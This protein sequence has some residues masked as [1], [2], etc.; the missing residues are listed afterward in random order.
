MLIAGLA[1][2]AYGFKADRLGRFVFELA[3]NFASHLSDALSHYFLYIY[4]FSSFSPLG[5]RNLEEIL[6]LLSYRACSRLVEF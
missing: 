5:K 2:A 1:C 6:Q 3:E 4:Y